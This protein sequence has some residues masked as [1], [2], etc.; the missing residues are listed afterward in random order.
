MVPD[1]VTATVA[2]CFEPW[3]IKIFLFEPRSFCSTSMFRG[4]PCCAVWTGSFTALG[5][6]VIVAVAIADAPVRSKT[7]YLKGK[8]PDFHV[9]GAAFGGVYLSMPSDGNVTVPAVGSSVLPAT[10][11]TGL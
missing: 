11:W 9:P 10:G 7:W 6:R 8:W 2:P 4:M 5:V 3:V 1:E